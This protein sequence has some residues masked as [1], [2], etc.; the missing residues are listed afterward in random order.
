MVLLSL[1]GSCLRRYSEMMALSCLCI[2]RCLGER[3]LG[4]K[5]LAV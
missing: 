3:S 1:L 4:T 2:E 5:F